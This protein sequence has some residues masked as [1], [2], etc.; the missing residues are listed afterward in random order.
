MEPLLV[1]SSGW[2]FVVTA[3]RSE[4]RGHASV[5]PRHECGRAEGSV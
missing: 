4:L 3:F 2:I 1:V 5:A